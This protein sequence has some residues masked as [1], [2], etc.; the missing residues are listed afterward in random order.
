VRF[1]PGAERFVAT[2]RCYPGSLPRVKAG[3][4]GCK[5]AVAT[6]VY[7]F[8]VMEGGS[9][10]FVLI[11]V[12][13]QRIVLISV[14]P[15]P[16]LIWVQRRIHRATPGGRDPRTPN[17]GKVVNP[18]TSALP[19]RSPAW[20]PGVSSF[21]AGAVLLVP[22]VVNAQVEV[23]SVDISAA[24][25][26]AR[27][28]LGDITGDGRL[29]FVMMQ[30]DTMADDRYI[31]HQVNALTAY[32]FDGNLL[33]QVGDPAQGSSTGSDIP[34]QIYDIDQDGENE[35][36]ACMNNSVVS[37]RFAI[38]DGRTGEVEGTLDYPSP[39]AHDTIIIANFSGNER[40]TDIVLKDRYNTLWAMDSNWNVL[41]QHA[42]NIGHYPWPADYDYDG[43]EELM[44]GFEYLES[45]GTQVWTA[46]Q[47]G[48]ADCIWVGDID[49]DPSN[50]REIA[51]GGADITVYNADGD[52][53]AREDMPVEP[54]NIAIGDFRPDLPGLEI[55][56]QDRRDRGT[57][58]EEAIF[59]WSPMQS[60]MLFY[61]TR[62]GWG[63]IANM[64][65]DWDGAGSDFISIWR[66]PSPPTLF[67][68]DGNE[69]VSF[70]EGYLMNADIDG[71][72]TQEVITFTDWS[73]IL[74][75]HDPIDL[76][77]AKSG[78][79]RPQSKMQYNFTRYWG[80]EYPPDDFVAGTGGAPATGGN[81]GAGGVSVGAGGAA[82]SDTGSGGW[83][84]GGSAGTG[85]AGASSTGGSPTT[86]GASAT[87]GSV[88]TGG[89]VGTGGSVAAGGAPGA[90]G[91]SAT[92][93]AVG[94]GGAIGTGGALATGGVPGTGGASATGGAPAA[95]GAPVA[96][97]GL[98]TGSGG[99]LTGSGGVGNPTN[100]GGSNSGGT[101]G[102]STGGVAGSAAP[103]PTA[104]ESSS[105]DEPGC[106]C[107][108]VGATRSRTASLASA[109]MLLLGLLS[110]RRRRGAVPAQ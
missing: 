73:A 34:A 68:G 43:H 72:G 20:C 8:G 44:A 16:S 94:T 106:G 71:D 107:E 51:L 101:V 102:G 18:R 62:S 76:E 55:A 88:G 32:D 59:C 22:S 41:F 104:A 75:S 13:S 70:A 17:G 19:R 97:G 79:P 23:A 45:D 65:H 110:R 15:T 1:L 49:Q 66:G 24:G 4:R 38:L 83:M 82:G 91:V 93:G 98:G 21:I 47:E 58:G 10:R 50:G 6:T 42:G 12:A 96:T 81:G 14:T 27:M 57:P 35:V 2:K 11:E 85:T 9:R 39:D 52:L 61:N 54:Q 69:A 63:S 103:A 95:G 56:G 46:D 108:T 25:T 26:G 92:G 28:L 36:L 78:I 89:A 109:L 80:G 100:S 31:G 105:G 33:W 86:G 29:D 67:D 64:V 74:Y 77:A 99:T 5:T 7:I 53:I 87:G 84:A 37:G 60:Q 48:H 90:G 3:R 30:G 40:P